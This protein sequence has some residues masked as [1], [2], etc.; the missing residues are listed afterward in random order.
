M[1]KKDGM[2]Q[3]ERLR[4]WRE[5]DPGGQ[6]MTPGSSVNYR[7]SD[8]TP[9]TMNWNPETCT[10]CLLCWTV[11]PDLCITVENEKMAGVDKFYCKGCAMCAQICPTKPKS[12]SFEPFESGE[13]D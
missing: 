4:T 11:C 3:K 1:T 12:L 10:H 7:S 6:V 13:E 5:V 8:W 2:L 9:R